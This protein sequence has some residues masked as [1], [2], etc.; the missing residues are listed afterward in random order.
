[1]LCKRTVSVYAC[2]V[3]GTQ[4]DIRALYAFID[5]LTVARGGEVEAIVAL[6]RC[7]AP[8]I[9]ARRVR[10]ALKRTT[11]PCARGFRA[12]CWGKSGPAFARIAPDR[13][14]TR[15]KGRASMRL[16]AAL[17]HIDTRHVVRIR[18]AGVGG[19]PRVAYARVV[20]ELV[21]TRLQR[22]L[23]THG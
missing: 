11:H 22:R 4:L 12:Q 3:R 20:V 18:R 9:R 14:V 16:V 13:I 8:Q 7:H 2:A 23:H 5:V 21:N 10:L 17:V 19:K 6:A 1:M 15:G